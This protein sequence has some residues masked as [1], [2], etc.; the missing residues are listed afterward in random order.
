MN[1][2]V[3]PETLRALEKLARLWDVEPEAALEQVVSAMLRCFIEQP[4]R[5]RLVVTPAE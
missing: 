5:P 4:P 2:E 1:V 3:S